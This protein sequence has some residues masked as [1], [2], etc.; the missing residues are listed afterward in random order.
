MERFK[1]PVPPPIA[2]T[3]SCMTDQNSAEQRSAL[4]KAFS[5]DIKALEFSTR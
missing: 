3:S 2:R 1:A 4:G 5:S